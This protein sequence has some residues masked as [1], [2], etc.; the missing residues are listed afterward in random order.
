[1]PESAQARAALA[2]QLEEGLRELG[3]APGSHPLDAYLDYIA[4]LQ[5]W[6]RAYS[7]SGIRE[8]AKMLAYHVLDSLAVLP[9]V[10]G[11]ACL[12]V[13]TGAGL[14]GFILALA[15]PQTHWVLLDGKGK[16][17]RF[18]N[19]LCMQL[20]P[21]NVQVIQSRV[22]D[23]SGAGGFD[24]IIARALSS[25]ADFTKAIAHL[26][27]P[28]TLILAMKGELSAPEQAL[29][30]QQAARI[31]IEKFAVPGVEA[32]RNLLIQRGLTVQ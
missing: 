7:L 16:K 4:L 24:L 30:K 9:F 14:P 22:E 1:M 23:F 21:K 11:Q 6:N 3:M 26:A 19:H 32:P 10:R 27:G 29:L 25:F 28:Q 2:A 17:I 13:G 12:D 20:K 31:R 8:P 5:K 18:L 15:A